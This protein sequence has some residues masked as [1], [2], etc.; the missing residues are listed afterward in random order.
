MNGP[1]SNIRADGCA[2]AAFHS[3]PDTLA[4]D[5]YSG[6]YGPNHSGLVLGTGTYLVWDEELG[7]LVAYGGLV[8]A[9]DG[10]NGAS[11]GGGGGGAVNHDGSDAVVTVH[12]RDVARR[13]VFVAPL[14]LLVEIDAGVIEALTYS[15]ANASLAVTLGQLATEGVPT[16]PSTVMWVTREDGADAGY[17]VTGTGLDITTTRLGWQ[18]PLA[19]GGAVAVVQVVPC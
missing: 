6:D 2:S 5:A 9:A 1:L 14:E 12:P 18:I 11:A 19:S 17:T 8:T 4:W 10:D 3:W 15:A 16:A 7:R 13:K